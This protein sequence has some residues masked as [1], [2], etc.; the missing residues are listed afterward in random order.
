[1]SWFNRLSIAVRDERI[2]LLAIGVTTFSLVGGIVTVL[3]RI[4]DQNEIVLA[5]PKTQY[6]TQDTE[7]ALEV[8]TLTKLLEH[9]SYSIREIAMKILCDRAIN[10]DDTTMA[11]LYG[12]TRP[13]YD[14]RMRCLR[15]LALLTGQTIGQDGLAKLNHT[16]AYSALVRSLELCLDDVERPDMRNNHWD[17]Y[18]LRDMGER[19]CLM[20]VLELISKYGASKLVKAKFVEKWLAKQRWGDTPEERQCSFQNYHHTKSNRIA[21]IITHIKHSRKGYHALEEAGLIVKE[22]SHRKCSCPSHGGDDA[23]VEA[24]AEA[25][26]EAAAVA[27]DAEAEAEGEEGGHQGAGPRSR[28]AVEHSAEEQ[29]LRRHNREAMVMND[30]TRPLR[31]EDIIE[32]NDGGAAS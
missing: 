23:N 6:I 30:G 28:R 12:I 2:V 19:L 29:R 26:A 4:R 20:F 22:R 32:V 24:E 13:D 18:F 5:E 8:D 3:T 7:D 17:E 10:D 9:P 15:A 14:E 25:E 1:M 27:A 31:R 21:D 16:K 11:L